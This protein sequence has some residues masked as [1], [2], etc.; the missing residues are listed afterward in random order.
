MKVTSS[1][2]ND[3]NEHLERRK[4]EDIYSAKIKSTHFYNSQHLFHYRVNT[5]L[6]NVRCTHNRWFMCWPNFTRS[7][8]CVPAKKHSIK[9]RPV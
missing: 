7:K 5:N 1:V 9:V 3:L 2:S 4:K 8:P 6:A